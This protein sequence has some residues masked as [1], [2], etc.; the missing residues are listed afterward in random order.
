MSDTP[1][2]IVPSELD[3]EAYKYNGKY[4][5]YEDYER[6]E[7]DNAELRQ[8][9]ERYQT[10]RRLSPQAWKDAWE[11]NIKTGKP[12]DEIIDELRAFVRPTE[13]KEPE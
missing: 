5:S 12:F 10:A 11:L 4:V 3:T 7:R 13:Q 8:G 1:K 6:I 2:V 9:H